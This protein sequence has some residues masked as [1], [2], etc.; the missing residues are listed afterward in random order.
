MKHKK[1]KRLLLLILTIA[2]ISAA[3]FSAGAARF[4]GDINQD[5]KISGPPVKSIPSHI[6]ISWCNSSLSE[7]NG[8]MIGRPPT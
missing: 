6:S 1:P 2:L 7:E 3:V 5:G 4:A 8:K